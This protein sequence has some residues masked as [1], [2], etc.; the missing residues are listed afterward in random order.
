MSYGKLKRRVF[1]QYIAGAIAGGSFVYLVNEIFSRRSLPRPPE[2]TV[3][4][5]AD[6]VQGA[7]QRGGRWLSGHQ[8]ADGA[9]ID[10]GFPSVWDTVCATIALTT[11]PLASEYIDTSERAFDFLSR[12]QRP[13]GAIYDDIS[14]SPNEKDLEASSLYLYLLNR[15][16]KDDKRLRIFILESQESDGSFYIHSPKIPEALRRFPSVTGYALVGLNS[17]IPR[18]NDRVQ[19]AFDY[20]RQSQNEMGDWGANMYYYGT[21][22]YAI[23]IISRALMLYNRTSSDIAQRLIDYL[24]TNQLPDGNFIDDSDFGLITNELRTIFALHS[25]LN[26]GEEN[27][28]GIRRGVDWL[29][30]RQL[31]SGN[32]SGGNYPGRADVLATSIALWM[33][34][35]YLQNISR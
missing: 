35:E 28:A 24:E 13:D 4:Q 23:W 6:S 29:L 9:I 12:A 17:E 25:L 11:S 32:W 2:E 34:S 22:Y 27:N 8:S 33:L 16:G 18:N 1:I 14:M 26:L 30:E 3:L 7:L 15:N 31:P 5:D 10:D 19:R 20:L 21:R